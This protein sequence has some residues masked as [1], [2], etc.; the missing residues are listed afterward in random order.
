MDLGN[1]R[2]KHIKERIRSGSKLSLYLFSKRNNSLL[3][4]FWNVMKRNKKIFLKGR[5][6]LKSKLWQHG[7]QF[8]LCDIHGTSI[9]LGKNGLESQALV[10]APPAS[11][12][13]TQGN[14]GY[15]CWSTAVEW[16][17][18]EEKDHFQLQHVCPNLQLGQIYCVLTIIWHCTMSSRR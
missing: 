12:V 17:F 11:Y 9:S 6:D 7:A 14:W 10:T 8:Q 18:W 15:W 2:L 4:F 3:M 16:M 1:N 13:T 5:G